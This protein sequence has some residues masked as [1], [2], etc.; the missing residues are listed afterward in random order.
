VKISARLAMIIS[1]LFAAVAFGIAITGLASINEV[2]DPAQR[3]DGWGYIC[4]WAFLGTIGVVFGL[5]SAW[6]VRTHKEDE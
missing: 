4:F 6:I 1:V 3:A 2:A 5:L